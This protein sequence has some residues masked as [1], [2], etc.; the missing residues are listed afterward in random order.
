MI[1]KI[2]FSVIG[3]GLVA[4][5]AIQLYGNKQ[6]INEAA[7]YKEEIGNIPVEIMEVT[8]EKVN[9][10]LKFTGTFQPFKEVNFGAETQGKIVQVYVN[11]GDYLTAG[12][13][14]AKIDDGML[15]LQLQSQAN[16]KSVSQVQLE[17][18]KVVAAKAEKD[19]QRF[20][21][22]K[23][24][25]AVADLT[26]ENQKLNL[27]QVKSGVQANELGLKGMDIA[28]EI[29]NEQI[30]KTVIKA[31]ISGYLTMKNFE[32]G[33]IAAP[34]MPL[35]MITDVSNLKMVAMVTEKEVVRFRTGQTVEVSADVFPTKTFTG[36][37]MQIATKGDQN[38]NFKVEVLIQNNNK[39]Y[40][41]RAGMYGTL[42]AQ[43]ATTENAIF[44]PNS[45]LLG[46]S[47]QA[48]VYVINNGKAILKN[49]T[50]GGSIG[51]RIE[52]TSGLKVGEKVIKTGINNLNN[53]ITVKVVK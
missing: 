21:N 32:V 11:E 43:T 29:T 16:Q 37:I 52:I 47:K 41:L 25:G 49:V 51:D 31:P 6:E 12:R 2:I 46:N 10:K 40:P 42:T 50:T 27:T 39:N 1:K 26:F 33:T 34:N 8:A 19:V 44:L 53:G 28:M 23:S 36:K 18:Q 13:T 30:S 4:L 3:V 17:T 15:Q 35:G 45:I 48:Q 38:H 22:L 7:T 5:A 20:N 24:D 14:I 9:Q